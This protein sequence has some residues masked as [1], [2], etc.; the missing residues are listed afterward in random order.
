LIAALE[1]NMFGERN[2]QV[3][4]QLE[5]LECELENKQAE[6]EK[7]YR[8]YIAEVSDENEYSERRKQLKD[9]V[10]RLSGQVAQLRPRQMTRE[11]FEAQKAQI[12]SM[13][14]H[15][16]ETGALVDPPFELKRRILKMTVDVIHVNQREGWF[17]LTGSIS[18]SARSRQ[19][20][21]RT[22]AA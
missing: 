5:Y 7:L 17:T 16:R 11:Q 18:P 19:S 1:S 6:D 12:L 9:E 3:R 14:E 2:E 22:A 21:R 8:A 15:L 4:Q 20:L 13:S 10:E